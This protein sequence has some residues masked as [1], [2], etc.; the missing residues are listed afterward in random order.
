MFNSEDNFDSQDF[1]IKLSS[2]Q[3]AVYLDQLIHLG[4]PHYNLGFRLQL[5]GEL[6]TVLVE[7]ALEHLIHQHPSLRTR[8]QKKEGEIFQQVQR[9][10]NAIL[11]LKDF[12]QDDHPQQSADAHLQHLFA[13]PFIMFGEMLWRAVL[14]HISGNNYIF[15]LYY[16]HV[17]AD[18]ISAAQLVRDFLNIYRQLSS[19]NTKKIEPDTSYQRFIIEDKEYLSSLRYSRDRSFWLNQ[20]ETVP[21]PVF[22]Y[23]P[24]AHKTGQVS[25]VKKQPLSRQLYSKLQQY[26]TEQEAPIASFFLGLVATYIAKTHGLTEITLGIPLHNRTK[27]V[28]MTTVGMFSSVMPM[29]I[30]IDRKQSF[31]GLVKQIQNQL[32]QTYRHQRFPL[33]EINRMCK[34][35]ALGRQQL[36]DVSVSYEVFDVDVEFEEGT[37]K[38]IRMEEFHQQLPLA[39]AILDYHKEDDV[40]LRINGNISYVDDVLINNL[41]ERL[42]C[43]IQTLVHDLSISLG[44]LPVMTEAE[45]HRILYSFNDTVV[46]YPKGRCIHEMFEVQVEKAPGAIDRKSVV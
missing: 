27:S 37:Y 14:V 43:M 33:A 24:K 13:Q 1:L 15:T 12:S 36:Y 20:F 25:Q 46:D 3:E 2:A 40:E 32:M 4:S 29:T 23:Q 45:Q 44:Q 7:E 42:V 18:G 6:N 38:N 31:V 28:Y 41:G 35:T 16:H 30:A 10:A 5:A 34:L 26:L 39:I 9:N 21:D 8:L 19:G 11:S 22:A 17:I